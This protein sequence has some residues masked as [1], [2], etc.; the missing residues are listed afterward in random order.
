MK[1]Y[2]EFIVEQ[3]EINEIGPIGTALMGAMALWGSTKAYKKVKEKITGYRKSQEEK[4]ENKKEGAYARIKTF[5]PETGK[6]ET[7]MVEIGSPG[8]EKAGITNDE[9]KKKEQELQ[10]K[11]DVKNSSLRNKYDFS[12][13]KEKEVRGGIED[14]NDAEE[15]FKNN[16]K[17]PP[18]WSNEFGTKKEPNL[19]TN[20]DAEKERQRRQRVAK[21]NNNEE[22]SIDLGDYI[23]ESVISDLKK[24]SQSSKDGEV[25]LKDGT[26]IP[27]EPI[28]A[29]ILVK[30]IDTLDSTQKKKTINQLQ[31][32]ERGF[33]KVL[34]KAHEV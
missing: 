25:T 15:Y 11:Q 10:K 8:S 23:V 9:L 7:K 3:Q 16:G 26:S 19:M 22:F 29:Q 6:E 34:G 14:V 5:N 17:A 33:L 24:T 1:S 18:G 13:E 28:T 12:Q 2:K 30:Y 21:K 20:K 4:K 27:V 31:R 32:T